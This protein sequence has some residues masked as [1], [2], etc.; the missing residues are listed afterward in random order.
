MVMHAKSGGDIE[1]MGLMQGKVKGGKISSNSL[2]VIKTLSTSWTPLVYQLKEQKPELTLV[3]KPMNTCVL[4]KM[5]AKEFLV[6]KTCVAG[7]TLTLATVVGCPVSMLVLNHSIKTIKN[8]GSLLLSTLN[9][10]WHQAE[11]ISL[12]SE[13]IQ[14]STKK[15]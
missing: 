15:N 2:I 5:H 14:K 7:I 4:T 6:L 8:L 11:L 9:A 12:A 1:I 13:L 10:P 3:M